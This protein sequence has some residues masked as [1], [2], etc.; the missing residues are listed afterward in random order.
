MIFK[1][2]NQLVIIGGGFSIKEGIDKGLWD[3]LKGHMVFNL[4]YAYKYNKD[5]TVLC[6]ADNDFY[7]RDKEQI[8][9]IPLIL[10]KKHKDLAYLPN[11]LV[12]KTTIHYDKTLKKGVYKPNLVGVFALTLG[13]YLLDKD[14]T[15]FL[16]GYD[17]S[18]QKDKKGRYIPDK[19]GNKITHWYQ[20][21]IK[22]RGI[23]KTNYYETI[24]HAERDFGVYKG[25]D[26]PK[27][28]NVSLNSAIENFPK[29]SY[30]KFFK[31]LDNQT[32]SQDELR[33]WIRTKLGGIK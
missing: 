10:V 32:Y 4:N 2:P 21:D 20:G 11:S 15:I 22:H 24:G 33:Q 31:Q 17:F 8:K 26:M 23:S 29:I 13:I 5:A 25:Q 1:L 7:E 19:K 30:D 12:F 9:D 18:A 3:K 27:I 6:M 14:S 16:L 28:L